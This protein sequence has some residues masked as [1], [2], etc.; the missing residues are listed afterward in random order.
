MIVI[1]GALPTEPGRMG[2]AQAIATAAARAGSPVQ[3]IGIVGDGPEGDQL[4]LK[5]AEAGVGHAAVLRTL[6]RPMEA[7]DITLAL[8]YLPDVAV[9]VATDL[10]PDLL[11]AV[12]DGA[13]FA[14]APL[15]VVRADGEEALPAPDVTDAATVLVAP[16]TDPDGTFAGFV[17]AFAGH[18]DGGTCQPMPGPRPCRSWR[19]I[20]SDEL[21]VV[22]GGQPLNERRPIVPDIVDRTTDRIGLEVR[23][24]CGYQQA[25]QLTGIG[26]GCIKPAIPCLLGEDH[27]HPVVNRAHQVVGCRGH[28]RERAANLVGLG[29]P[30]ARPQAGQGQGLRIGP[31]DSEGLANGAVAAP[32]EEGIDRH[33]ASAASKGI[34]EG[35]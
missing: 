13:G 34:P 18:L 9:V 17:A 4:L 33:Q 1:C 35:R 3:V 30:P 26:Q 24:G 6:D 21:E 15:V 31:H 11:G 7:A 14:G 8:R 28:D 5:L 32:L 19:S 25:L 29:I 10:G 12:A 27:R 2:M 16:K 23:F 22:G 20:R